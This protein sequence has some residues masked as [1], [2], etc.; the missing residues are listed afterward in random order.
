MK[1]R[2]V[3][4]PKPWEDRDALAKQQWRSQAVWGVLNDPRRA[5]AYL[6]VGEK[7]IELLGT[8]GE[9]LPRGINLKDEQ[10]L[11]VNFAVVLPKLSDAAVTERIGV[12]RDRAEA[13]TG[14]AE[15]ARRYEAK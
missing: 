8:L 13:V 4:A 14:L 12:E 9:W 6:A 1:A 11:E 15:M 7:L 5:A 3:D 10:T 2:K